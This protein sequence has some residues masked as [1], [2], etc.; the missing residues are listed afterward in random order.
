MAVCGPFRI[1][2]AL[3]A[4]ILLLRPTKAGSDRDGFKVMRGVILE[5]FSFTKS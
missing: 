3:N 1:N 5:I 2:L 4:A